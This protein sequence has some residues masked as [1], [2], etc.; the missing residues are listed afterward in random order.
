MPEQITVKEAIEACGRAVW[1]SAWAKRQDEALADVVY[2]TDP[3]LTYNVRDC[4]KAA[5]YYWDAESGVWRS[6]K[7]NDNTNA[8][9][10][11]L[12]VLTEAKH[13]LTR[14]AAKPQSGY[15]FDVLVFG[16]AEA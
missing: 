4:L 15:L 6:G 13:P 14:S 16:M 10:A 5:G 7:V 12:K 3:S 2:G 11:G 8:I 9:V 1:A